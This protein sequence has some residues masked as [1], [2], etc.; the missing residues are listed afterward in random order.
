MGLRGNLKCSNTWLFSTF[1]IFFEIFKKSPWSYFTFTLF[2]ARSTIG[3][4]N[5]EIW[6]Y[7]LEWYSPIWEAKPFRQIVSKNSKFFVLKN[8]VYKEGF[9]FYIVIK[10]E[11]LV[12]IIFLVYH[13]LTQV[14]ITSHF[15][16]YWINFF[17]TIQII[18][19]QSTYFLKIKLPIKMCLPK[20]FQV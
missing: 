18:N 12:L 9:L 3:Y 13:H 11:T 16:S 5:L 20:N 2:R 8:D 4:P 1:L 14:L 17:I 7:I 10:M 6:I 15:L 19:I